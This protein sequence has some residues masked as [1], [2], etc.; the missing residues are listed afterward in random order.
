MEAIMEATKTNKAQQIRD[1]L[2]KGMNAKSVAEAVG[3]KV[4]YVYDVQNAARRSKKTKKA[5]T[6][7][8]K[9]V[10]TQIVAKAPEQGKIDAMKKYIMHLETE[11]L[12]RDGA[13][14]AL[15]NKLYATSV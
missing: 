3:V 9:S 13:I 15:R 2:A 11:L 1:L 4:Q 5:A 6:L 8:K 12:M 7:A 14:N 10:Q